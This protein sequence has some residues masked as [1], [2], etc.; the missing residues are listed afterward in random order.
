MFVF[1]DNR[2]YFFIFILL[3]FLFFWV[4]GA[5]ALIRGGRLFIIIIL[6]RG[7]YSRWGA[8][9]R[10]YGT[11]KDLKLAKNVKAACII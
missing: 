5:G 11:S 1:I 6:R 2:F 4:G 9:S 10:N 7:A 3:I 8:K